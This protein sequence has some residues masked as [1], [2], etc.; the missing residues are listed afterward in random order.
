MFLL[1]L[2]NVVRFWLER[3]VA[4]FR[5]D[6]VNCLFEVDKNLHGGQYPDEPL[7]GAVG[8]SLDDHDSLD[9][10]YTKNQNETYY[11]VYDWRD[12]LDEF[13]ARDGLT[14]VMMTEVYATI[15]DVVKYFGEGDRKGA[16]MPFNFDLITD[17]DASSSA[18]DIKRAIDKFLTYKPL[19]KDANWVVR[20]IALG[21]KQICC[22]LDYMQDNRYY[23]LFRVI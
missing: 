10:I 8:V 13:K 6:A 20:Y 14:R 3:G 1:L 23:I 11:V 4:G 5:V 19:D 9:H 22:G 12:V 16:Q 21:K 2:Q 7:S 15:Q 18:G 17:V